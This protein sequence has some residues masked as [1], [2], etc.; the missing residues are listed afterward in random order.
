MDHKTAVSVNTLKFHRRVAVVSS[1]STHTSTLLLKNFATD[2]WWGKASWEEFIELAENPAY[3]DGR[4]YYHQGLIRIE[5]S[6]LQR[7]HPSIDFQKKIHQLDVLK[8]IIDSE[9]EV[10]FQL[11]QVLFPVLLVLLVVVVLTVVVVLFVVAKVIEATN[12]HSR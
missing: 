4:F 2:T 8:A 3:T 9:R 6:P 7:D 10:Q 5:M 12:Y 11:V 1:S